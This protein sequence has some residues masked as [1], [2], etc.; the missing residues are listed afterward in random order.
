[1]K[2]LNIRTQ[3]NEQNVKIRRSKILWERTKNEAGKRDKMYHICIHY[4][5]C[6]EMRIVPNWVPQKLFDSYHCIRR[7]LF[8][9]FRFFGILLMFVNEK[10][11]KHKIMTYA[12]HGSYDMNSTQQCKTKGNGNA[13]TLPSNVNEVE[14][15]KI[16]EK[17]D[18]DDD[19]LWTKQPTLILLN[20]TPGS[21]TLIYCFETFNI[22]PAVVLWFNW[23][24]FFFSL[25]SFIAA[26]PIHPGQF[27][28]VAIQDKLYKQTK[29][30]YVKINYLAYSM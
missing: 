13:L 2:E 28:S 20:Q 8:N 5:K 30:N 3:Q 6:K 4:H 10:K 26:S 24:L 27:Y 18:R 7:S 16:K 19:S 21:L 25:Y 29:K 22:E 11:K 12:V 9:S 1:M 14:R 23:E 17:R 15:S